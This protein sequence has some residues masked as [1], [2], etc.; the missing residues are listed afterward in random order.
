M[1]KS[2]QK[3][4]CHITANKNRNR[5]KINTTSILKTNDNYSYSKI[6]CIQSKYEYFAKVGKVDYILWL[7]FYRATW[8]TYKNKHSAKIVRVDL[9][10]NWTI[11]GLRP[12]TPPIRSRPPK[13]PSAIKLRATKLHLSRLV[14]STGDKVQ[15]HDWKVLQLVANFGEKL[16]NHADRS[17]ICYLLNILNSPLYVI[18]YLL[19]SRITSPIIQLHLIHYA[20]TT[21]EFLLQRYLTR[22]FKRWPLPEG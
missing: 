21:A 10:N 1:K 4:H 16:S 13:L 9:I 12:F 22:L 20:D 14:T 17:Q 8:C 11:I 19:S 15:K 7:R 18:P 6:V 5:S 3:Q 2:V